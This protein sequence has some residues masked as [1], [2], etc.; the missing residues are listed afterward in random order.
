M[1]IK[2]A[3]LHILVLYCAGVLFQ[4]K[5]NI[6]IPILY[7]FAIIFLLL[8]SIHF[9]KF[10]YYLLS[11]CVLLIGVT[12]IQIKKPPENRKF[13][14]QSNSQEVVLSIKDVLKGST[15]Y[16]RYYANVLKIDSK[17]ANGNILVHIER[18]SILKE[19]NIGDV[20][21]TKTLLDSVSPSMNPYTFDYKSYLLQNNIYEQLLLKSGTW[22]KISQTEFSMTKFAFEFRK[23][24]IQSLKQRIDDKD[25]L[26]ITV[27]LILGE[28]QYVS[29]ELQQNYANAGVIHILAV[30]GLHIGILVLLLNFLLQPLKRFYHGKLVVFLL[31]VSFLWIYAFIAGLSASVVRAVT[32]FSFMSLGIVMNNKTNVFHSLIASALILLL[33]N[34][35]F[36][37][38]LGFKMSYI[39]VVSIVVLQPLLSSLWKPKFKI[40]QYFWNLITVSIAAQVGLLPLSLYYFHQFPSLFI[41]SNLVVLPCLGLILILGFL[42]LICT[43]FEIYFV[44]LIDVYS[45][46]IQKLN[47]FITLISEQ[48][49]WLWDAVFFSEYMLVVSYLLLISFVFLFQKITLQRVYMLLCVVILFQATAFY[50]FYRKKNHNELIVYQQYK[51]SLIA[52]SNNGTVQFYGDNNFEKSIIDYLVKTDTELKKQR[53]EIPSFIKYKNEN[54]LVIDKDVFYKVPNFHPEIIIIR[55]SPKINLQRCIAALKPR[56]VIA[57]GS[58]YPSLKK[59]WRKTSQTMKIDFHDTQTQGAF[60]LK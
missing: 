25:V 59:K 53:K 6:E 7:L 51:K 43:R 10:N 31:I 12:A 24:M 50:E 27:A 11:I 8:A 17:R 44:S 26:A 4:F 55:N 42:V 37:F 14:R 35:Y 39:A 1:F 54:I 21:I 36:L 16:N 22:I 46:V 18:D 40:V 56:I 29:K 13:Q 15:Y 9:Y 23:K 33:F 58:N 34:P 49:A 32:M 5:Y 30:S 57:D 28:R 19:L 3:P 41:V 45:Y 38:S 20:I 2:Y 60:V 52:I 47:S 48:E